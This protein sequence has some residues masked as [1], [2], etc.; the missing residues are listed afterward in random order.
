M[1]SWE[2]LAEEVVPKFRGQSQPLLASYNDVASTGGE[3][4][5]VNLKAQTAYT[6]QYKAGKN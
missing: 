4:A 2:L 6:E 5:Q 1:R 3:G